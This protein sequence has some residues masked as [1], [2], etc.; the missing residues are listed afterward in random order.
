MP[1]QEIAVLFRSGFHSYKLEIELATRGLDFDKR[2]GLTGLPK[3][4][5]R[6]RG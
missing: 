2:G 1:L 6:Q 4:L 5:T 3:G